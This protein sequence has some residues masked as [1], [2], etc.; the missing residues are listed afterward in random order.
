MD[1]NAKYIAAFKIAI[2]HG[3]AGEFKP[4]H[5]SMYQ[6]GMEY[7]N[8]LDD[9]MSECIWK[10]IELAGIGSGAQLKVD[11]AVVP[12]GNVE[13]IVAEGT[14]YIKVDNVVHTD[15][16]SGFIEWKDIEGSIV[17]V[18]DPHIFKVD[19]KKSKWYTYEYANIEYEEDKT[20]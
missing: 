16:P 9:I 10:E 5:P 4:M 20:E 2:I 14:K 18:R 12:F 11:Y 15:E 17:K 1:T 19:R 6:I 7:L 8:K 3:I 13:N